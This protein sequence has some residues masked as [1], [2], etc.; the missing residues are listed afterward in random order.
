MLVLMMMLILSFLICDRGY[1]LMN[2]YK[3]KFLKKK[4]LGCLISDYLNIVK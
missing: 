3:K 1:Y 2:C 4:Y